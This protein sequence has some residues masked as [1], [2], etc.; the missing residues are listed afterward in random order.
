MCDESGATGESDAIRKVS[1]EECIKLHGANLSKGKTDLGHVDCFILSGS[2]VLE[3]VGRYVVVAVGTTSF[4]GRIMMGKKSPTLSTNFSLCVALRGD[5]ENTPL[6]LKL[7]DLAELIAKIGSVAGLA[8]FT[9]LM[10][11]FFVQLG[12]HNPQR[13]A[14]FTC[15]IVQKNLTF[16]DLAMRTR[17]ALHLST[18]SSY[19]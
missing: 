3:G 16:V 9:A 11:R 1:Y 4:N 17:T 6:Q 15:S 5:A 10:I 7:N 18:F 13:F 12:Q 14:L 19:Q 8:L 2:K